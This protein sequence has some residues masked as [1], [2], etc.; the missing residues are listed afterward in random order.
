ME[1][2]SK[3]IV[4]IIAVIL[5]GVIVI[6]FS[7]YNINLNRLYQEYIGQY[8]AND[9]NENIDGFLLYEDDLNGVSFLYPEL[10]EIT[11]ESTES[12]LLIVSNN[13]STEN[14]IV[15]GNIKYTYEKYDEDR[16]YL[17]EKNT[18]F[19]NLTMSLIESKIDPQFAKRIDLNGVE[20]LASYDYV[21]SENQNEDKGLHYIGFQWL[22]SEGNMCDLT[23]SIIDLLDYDEEQYITTILGSIEIK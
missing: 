23:I 11:E 14:N 9:I 6:L 16:E 5:L 21:Y 8:L 4:A 7:W 10:W 17:F 12:N 15:Q 3:K 22:S 2:Y 13:E 19:H 1:R 18:H 20:V